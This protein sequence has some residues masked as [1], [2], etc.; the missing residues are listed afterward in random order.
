MARHQL[1]LLTFVQ[2]VSPL[3]FAEENIVGGGFLDAGKPPVREPGSTY[4]DPLSELNYTVQLGGTAFIPCT[5][6]NLANRSVSWLRNKDGAILTVDN[7]TYVRDDRINTIHHPSSELWVLQIRT[8]S[9]ADAGRYECQVSTEPKMSHFNHLTIIVPRVR[10]FG[11]TDIYVK[12][13]SSVQLK[14]VISEIITP[15]PFIVWYQFSTR[16]AAGGLGGGRR[17]ATPPEHISDTTSMSTLTIQHAL[18]EDS[19]FYTCDPAGLQNATVTLHVIPGPD[20]DSWTNS[21][22]RPAA[23]F[24]SILA[25]VGLLCFWR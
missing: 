7:Y 13:G 6:R 16:I 21:S 22:P 10:I 4:F 25:T 8:V 15:P 18:P 2:L 23:Y 14:C 24:F 3:H 5:V 20:P 11:D 17:G 12:A 19:G 1:L 9:P